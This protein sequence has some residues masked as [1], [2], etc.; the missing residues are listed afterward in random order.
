M[1][2]RL[3]AS[4]PCLTAVTL[5]ALALSPLTAP[6]TA[7]AEPNATSDTPLALTPPMGWNNWAH[8]MCDIDEAKVVANADAL[9]RTGLAAKG[10]DTVTVDDCWM[11]TTR[12]AR[13]DLVTDTAK[14]PHGMAWLGEYL[15]AKGLKFG[16]YQDAGSLTCEKYPGSGAPAGGGAD[17][18]DQD[19]RLFASWK[20]DY[21]KMD[22]CNLWV[23]PGKTKEQ[24]YRD[25]YGA[26]ARALR[27]SGRDMVLSASAPA[28]FQQ[29]EWG[30]SDWHK[31]LGWVGESGQLWREGKDIKVYQPAAPATSRWSSVMGN[32]G[33]N[34][35]LGRYAG[36][37]NWND[38][39]FLIAGAPGLTEAESRSQVGLWAMMAAPF[40]LSSDVSQLTPA[41]LK[42]LGNAD[43]I[44]LDQDPMGRQGAVVSSNAT[45]EVLA[46]PLA[47]GDRAVAV[48]N[49]SGNTRD[50]S[51][52]L[53]DIGLDSCTVD[54]KDLWSGA[55]TEVSD[56]L[57][58]KLAGHDTAVW[59][60]SPRGCADAVPTG[61][62]NG[63]GAKCADGA[64]T[65][66]VGAVV[67]ASCT[68]GA[69][70]RWTLGP[71]ASLRLAGKCLSAGENG[72]VELAKCAAGEPGQ[73]WTHRRDGALVEAV[74]EL[75][76]TA[77]AAAATPDA[78]AER[79][80]LAECG[81]HRVDQAWSLPV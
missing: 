53:A 60:L 16:I 69:D 62:I 77:P 76:L 75:C 1:P 56:S 34:R 3:R 13:G 55:R 22:G 59:R 4:L 33:Y 65:T 18:Y 38:P 12:D 81:D 45:F 28:Y 39:D 50:I 49:R 7:N 47:N 6:T 14:F 73:S 52:P 29:G 66:G 15:H 21:V 61:Q 19:A 72:S 57:T 54:A 51:V 20:V 71:D 70:Q 8:Y 11:R 46:R 74:S 24:A 78:P 64:N 43:L 48:L 27:D 31:V 42:A 58:G 30:G 25:A 32:Y 36:P 79:L 63:D 41:G 35:W 10:Y 17:H 37:G 68:A 26:V 80:R 5:F 40:I 9:V 67:M 2:P 44:E 23:P